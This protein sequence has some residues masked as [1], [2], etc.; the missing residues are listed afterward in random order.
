M[1]VFPNGS[2][3]FLS[4]FLTLVAASIWPF[5]EGEKA[6]GFQLTI[7][8]SV[9]VFIFLVQGWGLKT[10]KIKKV[11]QNV[12]GIFRVHS[13]IFLSP[14]SFVL[15]TKEIGMIPEAL[16]AGFIFL[17][18]L[19][20][21][22]S[23]CVVYSSNA[24]GDSDAAMGHATLSNLLAIFWVPIAWVT[25]QI[26]D[27][28]G[29][30]EMIFEIGY[31]ILPKICLLVILPC[32][33]G[34]SFQSFL[35]NE[36]FPVVSNYLKRA[37]FVGILVLV[38]LSFSQTISNLGRDGFADLFFQSNFLILAFLGWNLVLSWIGTGILQSSAKLRV[39]EF[40][41]ASQKSLAM[42]LPL[43]SVIVP[44]HSDGL[45]LIVFPLILYHFLQLIIGSLIIGKLKMWV[46]V[47]SE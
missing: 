30:N 23:S 25:V 21:T 33:I 2:G 8:Q 20:T 37:T 32:F 31:F 26:D 13:L 44:S 24:D 46:K 28:S 1:R 18:I 12:V 22:I 16:Q 10:K 27:F 3:L 17:A 7:S 36:K 29:I 40:F 11:S 42:G 19:P 4:I 38:Y 14:L 43:A 34:W 5:A 6:F 9:I 45:A 47:Q 41:C 39:S 35:K 15:L